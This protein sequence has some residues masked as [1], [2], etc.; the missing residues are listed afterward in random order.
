MRELRNAVERAM[1]FSSDN[2]LYPED[3]GITKKPAGGSIGEWQSENGKRIIDQARDSA[4]KEIIINVL[5]H[6]DGNKS[7]AAEYLGIARPVLDQKMKRLGI[8]QEF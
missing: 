2:I 7:R 5:E 8:K 3:F 6:F 1:N 4:E